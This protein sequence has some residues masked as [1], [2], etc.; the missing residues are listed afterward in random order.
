MNTVHITS[1]NQQQRNDGRTHARTHARG[2]GHK[3]QKSKI[4]KKS[5]KP[6]QPK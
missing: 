5:P 2:G 6:K 3:N 1:T 4:K